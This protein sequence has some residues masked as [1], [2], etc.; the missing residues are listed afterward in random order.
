MT[1]TRDPRYMRTAG[2]TLLALLLVVASCQVEQVSTNI[3]V[4][5]VTPEAVVE[6]VPTTVVEPEAGPVD[7]TATE[8]EPE[9]EA[10]DPVR[11]A[12]E[13][14]REQNRPEPPPAQ[15]E[16]QETGPE[17][18]TPIQAG[19]VFTPMTVRPEI[20]NVAEV[21]AA[22][23]REYPPILRGAGIG[24]RVFVWFYISETGQVTDSRISQSS[25]HAALDE[26][27]LKVA[28]VFQFTPAVNRDEPVPVWIQLPIAFQVQ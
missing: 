17:D 25:G 15:A 21:Q 9:P 23:M 1:D 3:E 16:P 27:A 4:E 6:P 13:A 5:Q 11:A 8:S 20:R 10:V 2:L 12:I 19:P 14:L 24:G 7:R 26:A 28:A 22:L 18:V